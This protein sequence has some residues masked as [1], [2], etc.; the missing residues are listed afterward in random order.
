[1]TDELKSNLKKIVIE[2]EDLDTEDGDKLCVHILQWLG[3]HKVKLKS[4]WANGG[5]IHE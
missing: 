2:F 4:F 1:M 3:N 5:N